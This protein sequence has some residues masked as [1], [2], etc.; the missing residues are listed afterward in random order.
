VPSV[1]LFTS[2]H[3]PHSTPLSFVNWLNYLGGLVDESD[4]S[5]DMVKRLHVTY[6][7]PRHGHILQKFEDGVGNVFESSQI[8]ALVLAEAFGGHVSMV[9]DYFPNKI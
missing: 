7:L 6:L 1:T 8:N 4:S 3:D 2:H 5:C 9:F